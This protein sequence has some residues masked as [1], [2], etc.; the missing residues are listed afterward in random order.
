VMQWLNGTVGE[1]GSEAVGQKGCGAIV[2]QCTAGIVRQ[3]QKE[4]FDQWY[5]WQQAMKHG[6]HGAV[7]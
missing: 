6:D 5:G 3:W 2:G 7:G 1:Q 4:V